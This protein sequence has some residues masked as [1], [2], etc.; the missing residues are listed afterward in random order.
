MMMQGSAPLQFVIS[1][2]ET[3]IVNL[4]SRSALHPDGRPPAPG[5]GKTAGRRH[6]RFDRHWEGDT[7]VVDTVGVKDPTDFFYFAPPLSEDARYVERLRLVAP[8]RIESEITIEDS[9]DA[10]R[11]VARE[12]G[13][14]SHRRHGP[15]RL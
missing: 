6:G 3:L 11:A 8:G 1:P 12:T 4:L 5:A 13:L 10:E 15:H 7:L 9:G 2:S 14:S